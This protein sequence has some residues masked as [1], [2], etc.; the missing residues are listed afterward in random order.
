MTGIARG[1]SWLALSA[2]PGS[3]GGPDWIDPQESVSSHP[4]GSWDTE[5]PPLAL[6]PGIPAPSPH[7]VMTEHAKA[8]SR[9]G[10][11]AVEEGVQGPREERVLIWSVS[12]NHHAHV[13]TITALGLVTPEREPHILGTAALII[14]STS[15]WFLQASHAACAC[16]EVS[17]VQCVCTP[18]HS[19][20]PLSSHL[21]PS[22][23]QPSLN[24]PAWLKP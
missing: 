3:R 7:A 10:L 1:R 9:P 13:S 14:L 15:C 5:L 20:T 2:V 6:L 23:Y 24:G 22:I 12:G 17:P 8:P 19:R 18:T 16:T 4:G 11:A 21:P